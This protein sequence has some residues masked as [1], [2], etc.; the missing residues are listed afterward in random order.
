MAT[1]QFIAFMGQSNADNMFNLYGD[2]DSGA[3]VLAAEL[4]SYLGISGGVSASTLKAAIQG[5]GTSSKF[6]TAN[7]VVVQDFAKGAS[8]VD[9]NASDAP[10]ADFLW[11][12][13]ET[14]TPGALALAAI[15]GINAS[16]EALEAQGYTVELKIVWAQGEADAKRIMDGTSDV[17]TYKEAT[18]EVLDYIRAQTDPAAPVFIQEVADT[19][20][21]GSDA[22]WNGGQDI[23]REA[24]REIA[25][26]RDDIYIGSITEDLPLKDQVHTDN[27]S[28]EVV[29]SRLAN[30]IA[31]T[32]G[33]TGTISGPRPSA[34]PDE[35]MEPGD[36]AP[37]AVA[38]SH[39]DVTENRTTVSG[40]FNLLANDSDV[41]G[42]VL[43]VTQATHGSTA[44]AIQ[45]AE[46]A[47]AGKY[48]TFYISPNGS[49]YYK[50]DPTLAATN[51]IAAGQ[52]AE[53]HLTYRISDGRGGTAS[54]VVTVTI[55]GLNDAPTAV[56][57]TTSVVK[58]V[59]GSGNLLTNDLDP[60]TGDILSVLSGSAG[61]GV[62]QN[63]TTGGTTIA[64]SYGSLILKSDGSWVYQPN[65]SN[66]A[67]A[68]LSGSAS[69]SEVFNY[70]V[71]DS[72]GLQSSALLTVSIRASSTGGAPQPTISGTAAA[73]TLRGAAG[74]DVIA[75][76]GGNDTIKGLTGDDILLG[77]DGNDYLEGNEGNDRL[78]GGAGVDTLKGGAG[79]D[80]FVIASMS[81]IGDI[82][83][84][85]RSD[86]FLDLSGILAMPSGATGVSAFAAGYIRL[87]QSGA[88]TLVEV[89]VDG[90]SGPGAFATV[91]T[92]SGTTASSV[93][94]A[95]FI[96]TPSVPS[97]PANTAPSAT[98]EARSVSEDGPG[99]TVFG[100]LLANDQDSDGD[101]LSVASIVI[102]GVT[103]SLG[104]SQTMQTSYGALTIAAN[105]DYSFTP[106]A[107]N[108]VVN[109]LYFDNLVESFEYTVSD[110]RGGTSKASLSITIAGSNDAPLAVS[111]IGIV[112][113]DT[114]ATGNVLANDTDPDAG[115]FMAL[116]RVVHGSS[117]VAVTGND[118]QL[119]G[120][121]GLLVID[122]DGTYSYV[123]NVSNPAVSGLSGGSTLT[124]TFNY[125]IR[126]ET[127][128]QSTASLVFT[129]KGANHA[130]V[131][132]DDA[133]TA[134][135]G[136]INATGT[137]L[138]NDSDV[139][140]GDTLTVL[141]ASGTGTTVN[142]TGA[143]STIAG[144]FGTL[145]L[146]ADGSWSYDVEESNPSVA[147]LSETSSLTDVF[148]Y[149]IRDSQGAV[150]TA[151][152]SLTVKG[153]PASGGPGYGTPTIVGTEAGETISGLAGNDIIEG[154][155]G[156]DV[157]KGRL[158]DDILVGGS[159][160]DTMEG[161]EGNDILYGGTGNDQMK[162][163]AG[164]DTFWFGSGHGSDIVH[165]LRADDT[166]V[167]TSDLFVSKA[168][169]LAA[170]TVVSANELLVATPDGG[171]IQFLDTTLSDLQKSG[172]AMGDG[173]FV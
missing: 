66:A 64:G 51:A 170:V 35:V 13:P 40:T 160:N 97:G 53:E 61:G 30:Y 155:G 2:N 154:R 166:L 133:A 4:S 117:I 88:D 96:V 29:G 141:S 121:Y 31:Y 156:N 159:G 98:G 107:T 173:M 68:A 124:E 86:D 103:Y 90:A 65:Q 78:D 62:T 114:S 79:A 14:N 73:D 122:S 43:R 145:L 58:T 93:K 152:L 42:D 99:N 92:L 130:P 139:D 36:T 9:G 85:F 69:L 153:A 82:V 72:A 102:K 136:A 120:T 10:S 163:G 27:E 38:D 57:D 77:G 83:S 137:V 169:L 149:T 113:I 94:A 119:A 60:D 142:V 20:Y 81:E 111:D 87:S 49:Y 19:A 135:A 56:A 110:S 11:W 165:Q 50:V 112:S 109:A 168:A 150:A 41:D 45:A 105:G 33:L 127:G 131:A 21:T 25:A 17:G 34:D 148:H 108:P 76:L 37:F 147:G 89:D 3:S 164:A 74:A 8:G 70:T 116:T 100:N 134:T 67:V 157:I 84:D 15:R 172:F 46:T 123:P 16:V 161:N 171:S 158:G 95:Q 47:V 7:N 101:I 129:I 132:A 75:G 126:D 12:Y 138:G 146:K 18:V 39:I 32:E 162:G 24:Q 59:S 71:R 63:V 6:T 118:T 52:T 44:S 28:Y 48:G 144:S 125:T 54:A 55:T 26:S 104:A 128:L 106:S 80:T 143:G 151:T 1:I 23:V 167:F 140:T 115:D 5:T 91:A 22:R